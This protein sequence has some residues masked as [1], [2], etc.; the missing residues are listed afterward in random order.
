M[1]IITILLVIAAY[2]AGATIPYWL[3][4]VSDP[5]QMSSAESSRAWIEYGKGL[6]KIAKGVAVTSTED[7]GH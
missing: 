2:P 7:P 3:M 1:K 6:E 4:S 5:P